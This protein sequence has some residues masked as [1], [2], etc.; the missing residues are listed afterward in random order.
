[1]AFAIVNFDNPMTPVAY[2]PVL[3]TQ[4]ADQSAGNNVIDFGAAVFSAAR[5]CVDVKTPPSATNVVTATLQVGTGAA[6]TNPV[7]IA[8]KAVT[9]QSGDTTIEF[10]MH[11]ISQVL[12]RSCKLILATS[13][14]SISY[15]A[16]VEVC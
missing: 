16:Q 3:T 2:V 15:D 5:V 14:N 1:M 7:N 12:F 9:M 6:V 4:Y 10:Q 11:G 8:Q 13:A